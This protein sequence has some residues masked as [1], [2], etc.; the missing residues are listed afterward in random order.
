V[1][2]KSLICDA[3][4]WRWDTRKRRNQENRVLYFRSSI[5]YKVSYRMPRPKII[6]HTIVQSQ[7]KLP[8]TLKIST[9]TCRQLI[10]Q[11]YFEELEYLVTALVPSETACW[12]ISKRLEVRQTLASSP[13]RIS[14]TAV[15]ISRDEIVDFLL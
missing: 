10:L 9:P 13:G 3:K 2:G 8:S 7:S 4:R 5:H 15:W 6:A 12:E 14:R 1:H 11:A